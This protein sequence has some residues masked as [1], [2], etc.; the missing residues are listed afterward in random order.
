MLRG[1]TCGCSLYV[2]S[3]A[4]DHAFC[5][6]DVCILGPTSG[7]LQGFWLLTVCVFYSTIV[8]AERYMCAAGVFRS[9]IR[10]SASRS[11]TSLTL[12]QPQCACAVCVFG[13]AA[14]ELGERT[15]RL[16]THCSGHHRVRPAF[17]EPAIPLSRQCAAAEP[18]GGGICHR[19]QHRADWHVKWKCLCHS[20]SSLG[21]IPV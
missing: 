10:G 2:V 21:Q 15:G 3:D 4:D 9:Q 14:W 13:C 18:K 1:S 20:S 17:P 8:G 5:A 16:P 12:I 19:R 11:A 7:K 6:C